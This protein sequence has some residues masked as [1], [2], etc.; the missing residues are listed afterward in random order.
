MGTLPGY[1][2]PSVL[3]AYIVFDFNQSMGFFVGALSTNDDDSTA[4]GFR[5]VLFLLGCFTN[6]YIW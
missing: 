6:L 1:L 2:G 4:V 5:L 3:D